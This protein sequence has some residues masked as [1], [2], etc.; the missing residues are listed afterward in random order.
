MECYLD[1]SATTQAYPEV[2]QIMSKMLLEDYGN[3]SS[4]HNKGMD[5]EV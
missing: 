4:M 1:N 2:A 3:P 5:A